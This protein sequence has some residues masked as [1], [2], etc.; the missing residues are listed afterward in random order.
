MHAPAVG[1]RFVRLRVAPHEV[2]RVRREAVAAEAVAPRLEAVAVAH[3]A[4]AVRRQAA[5]TQVA[6]P[7]MAAQ[8]T[9][10]PVASLLAPKTKLWLLIS[11]W[12]FRLSSSYPG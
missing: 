9:A 8:T 7:L 3:V 2:R 1:V 6:P 4:A 10:A 11:S 5:P 12:S